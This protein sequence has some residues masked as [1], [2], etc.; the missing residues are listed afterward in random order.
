MPVYGVGEANGLHYYV[1][2]FIQG[3]GL[4]E[5]LVE[6]RRLRSK[7]PGGHGEGR[8][9]AVKVAKEVSAVEVARS[10]LTGHFSIGPASGGRQPPDECVHQEADA[11]R[12]PSDTSIHLP[13][14]SGQSTLSETGK[15]Y[16]QSVA[17]V[18]VQVA[19]ALAYASSQGILHRDIKP[20]N[21][22]LDAQGTVWVTD[23]GL[24]KAADSEDL[25]H[26]GDIV[27]TLRYMAP[28][29]FGGSCDVRS[30]LYALGLTLYELLT[31]QPAFAETDRNKLLQQVMHDDPP[32]PRKLSLHVPRNLE[33]VVLK[34]TARVPEQRY[35]DAGRIGRGSAAVHRHATGAGAADQRGGE[36][37]A[38]VPP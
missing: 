26:T 5:V 22:L 21:L 31:L 13:G 38:L 36:A 34:A 29:R 15:A 25:T 35:P 3:L 1:M 4:D 33:T 24:A 11:P 2:Q 16:W 32:P 10:L 28:E 27:G 9:T 6:L 17:R 37:L 8:D 18:G 23:F 19:E 14:Q 12:S 20:S 30:D 7:A